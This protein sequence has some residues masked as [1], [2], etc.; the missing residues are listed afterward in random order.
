MPERRLRPIRVCVSCSQRKP[1]K[2]RGLCNACYHRYYFR[3]A[4]D[5]FPLVRQNVSSRT[6][7]EGWVASGLS[8]KEYAREIGILETSLS[9]ALRIERARRDRL[10]MTWLTGYRRVRGDGQ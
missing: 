7:Y 6:R 8:P 2:S 1:H 3:M 5:Q 9:R 10:G 4:L